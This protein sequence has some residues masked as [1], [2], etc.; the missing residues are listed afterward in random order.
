MRMSFINL[1]YCYPHSSLLPK[2]Q[3]T[4][5]AFVL[6]LY[7][8]SLFFRRCMTTHRIGVIWN[9]FIWLGI[10]SIGCTD[11]LE[12]VVDNAVF[13]LDGSQLEA[14]LSLKKT[15]IECGQEDYN[16]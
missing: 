14:Q 7:F 1:F 5:Q 12:F 2:P 11:I 3:L 10:D 13:N 15:L 16:I 6:F 8:Q 4:I 9:L